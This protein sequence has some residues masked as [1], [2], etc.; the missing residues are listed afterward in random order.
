[1]SKA[2]LKE[3]MPP[4]KIWEWVWDILEE[5]SDEVGTEENGKYLLAYEGWGG[6][7]VSKVFDLTKCDKENEDVYYKFA[8]EESSKIIVEWLEKYK[9]HYCLIDCGHES[10]GLYGVTWALFEKYND[11]PIASS[12]KRKAVG[13][14]DIQIEDKSGEIVYLDSK[15]YNTLTK[16]QSFR[17]FYFSPSEDPKITTD[18]FHLLMSFELDT[19]ERKGKRAFIPISW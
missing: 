13:Y 18:A 16:G 1:M 17:T 10:T 6:L 19:A 2:E 11:K 8:E 9:D 5:I 14:P 7:C 12:G 15:T 3:T 4:P